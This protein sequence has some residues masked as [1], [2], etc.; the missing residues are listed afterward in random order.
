MAEVGRVE[1]RVN[2]RI[3]EE[4]RRELEELVAKLSPAVVPPAKAKPVIRRPT[5]AKKPEPSIMEYIRKEYP[6]DQVLLSL[7]DILDKNKGMWQG[8][9]QL[10][11][12]GIEC[13]DGLRGWNVDRRMEIREPLTATVVLEI[14][15][16]EGTIR[17]RS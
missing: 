7:A 4:A 5:A 9:M 10:F 16:K 11:K 17:A 14:I 12:A 8:M 1:V 3:S 6:E 15:D 2:T 13:G